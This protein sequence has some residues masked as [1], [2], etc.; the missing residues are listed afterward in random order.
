[1]LETQGDS[2][3]S[4]GDTGNPGEA[5]T[6]RGR[7][8]SQGKCWKSG[9]SWNSQGVAWNP[10]GMLEFPDS[11]PEYRHFPDRTLS[12]LCLPSDI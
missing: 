1:M 6:P 11:L 10:R 8:N 3:I 2:G 12:I 4:K 7:W 5:G 9:G